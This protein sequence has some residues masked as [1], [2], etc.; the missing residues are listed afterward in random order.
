M[1]NNA[2][3][4]RQTHSPETDAGSP[5]VNHMT[6]PEDALS[7][8]GSTLSMTSLNS[9]SLKLDNVDGEPADSQ[10]GEEST[11]FDKWVKN[12]NCLAKLLASLEVLPTTMSS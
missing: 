4:E 9:S 6:A 2:S 12:F 1:G 3:T 11:H 10:K 8:P 7:V 5:S